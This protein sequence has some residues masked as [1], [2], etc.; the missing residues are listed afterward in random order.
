MSKSIACVDVKHIILMI[1]DAEK[2]TL[3]SSIMPAN[4]SRGGLLVYGDTMESPKFVET[5]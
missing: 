3:C 2:G 4:E 1:I 5:C